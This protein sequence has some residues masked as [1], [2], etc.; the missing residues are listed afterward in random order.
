MN[1]ELVNKLGDCRSRRS[2]VKTSSAALGEPNTEL[3][4]YFLRKHDRHLIHKLILDTMVIELHGGM[5]TKD[6]SRKRTPGGILAVLIRNKKPL[7]V[8]F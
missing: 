7:Y 2:F 5:L 6:Q 1:V 3:L 8:Y 4:S